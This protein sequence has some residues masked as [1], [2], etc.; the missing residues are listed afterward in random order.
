MVPGAKGRRASAAARRDNYAYLL[1][2][3]PTIRNK[4]EGLPC[5]LRPRPNDAA[6]VC[7]LAARRARP[8]VTPALCRCCRPLNLGMKEGRFFDY[9]VFV[10]NYYSWIVS[11]LILVVSFFIYGNWCPFIDGIDA[12]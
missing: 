12:N 11:L 8:R 2:L 1:L 3:P 4:T 9:R 7:L 10:I 5:A 6:A